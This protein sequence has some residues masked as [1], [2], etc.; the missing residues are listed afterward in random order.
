MRVRLLSLLI[1]FGLLAGS[2]GAV[3]PEPLAFVDEDA[4][5]GQSVI[6][7]ATWDATALTPAIEAWE[8][9]HPTARVVVEIRSLGDH[10]TEHGFGKGA[11]Q[12]A[13]MGGRYRSAADTAGR[14][15]LRD[16][17]FGVIHGLVHGVKIAEKR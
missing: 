7:V 17:V 13:G 9:E 6:R 10:H 16:A 5:P 15:N 2:C 4:R 1:M 14:I 8:A 3:R 12:L 11:H